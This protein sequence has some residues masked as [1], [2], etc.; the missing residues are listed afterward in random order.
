MLGEVHQFAKALPWLLT[1]ATAAWAAWLVQEWEA[2]RIK[3]ETPMTLG[4]ATK[5]FMATVVILF[6]IYSHGVS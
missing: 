4:Y 6:S 1:L 2:A 5:L 3:N